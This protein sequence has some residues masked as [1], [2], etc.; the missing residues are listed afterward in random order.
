MREL[1]NSRRDD[2][3]LFTI[4]YN[5]FSLSNTKLI[6]SVHQVSNNCNAQ[7]VRTIILKFS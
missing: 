3:S 1:P 5:T 6:E 7:I 2:Y 4:M